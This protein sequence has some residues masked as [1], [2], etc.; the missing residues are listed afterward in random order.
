VKKYREM[1]KTVRAIRVTEDNINALTFLDK[2]TGYHYIKSIHGPKQTVWPGVWLVEEGPR[3]WETMSD[4]GFRETYE[5]IK[6]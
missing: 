2:E 5:E 1:G 6:E 4:L 3:H